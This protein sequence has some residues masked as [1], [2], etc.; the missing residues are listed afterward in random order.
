MSKACF[1]PTVEKR[2]EVKMLAVMRLPEEDIAAYVHLRSVKSLH[3][4]FRKELAAG[5]A[6]GVDIVAGT[7]QT[8]AESGDAAAN[9][10]WLDMIG[11]ARLSERDVIA[12]KL[13]MVRVPYLE[14]AELEGDDRDAA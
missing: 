5:L 6:E 11:S 4:Y 14:T 12:G 7:L 9:T 13:T 8:M 10:A 1:K 3:K 2:Q